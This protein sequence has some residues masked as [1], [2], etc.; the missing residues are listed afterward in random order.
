MNFFGKLSM[1]LGVHVLLSMKQKYF[2][3]KMGENWPKMS[4]KT[5]FLLNLLENVIINFF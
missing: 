1:V 3:P 5:F 4:Q 2:C